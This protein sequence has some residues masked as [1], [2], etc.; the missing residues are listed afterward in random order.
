MDEEKFHDEIAATL[1]AIQSLLARS[2]EIQMESAEIDKSIH[3]LEKQRTQ[4]T[5]DMLD[6]SELTNSLA[7]QQTD[8]AR[9]RTGLVREQTRLSTKSTELGVIRTDLSRERSGLA[10]QRTDLAVLRTDL[11]RTR[12]GLAEQRNKM[13]LNR[14]QY[15]VKRTTLAVSRT[16][17][18]NIRTSMAQGRT[19]LALIRTGL[20]FFSIAI[21]FFRTFGLSWWSVFDGVLAMGS[22]AMTGAG[23]IGYR[24]ATRD[25]KNM[26]TDYYSAR[27]ESAA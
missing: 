24:R 15:S 11:S 17:L 19:H 13:A 21:A 5:S 7:V 9:E 3:A 20:A 22:L 27:E 1:S 2:I 18:S 6:H 23:I 25:V 12:T 4:T 8:M 26:Q 16:I 14:T 10:G